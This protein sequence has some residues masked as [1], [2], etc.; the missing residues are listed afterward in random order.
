MRAQLSSS[1][2]PPSEAFTIVAGDFNYVANSADRFCKVT[3][4]WTGDRD[5]AEQEEWNQVVGA[6]WGLNELEQSDFTHDCASSRSRI[7]RVYTNHHLAEQLDSRFACAAL[8][9]RTRLSAHRCLSFYRRARRSQRVG[10]TRVSTAAVK[11]PDFL[12]AWLFA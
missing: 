10:S 11:H 5:A 3:C 4:E 8:E 12:R 6:P 9:W 2:R 1:F 7:D